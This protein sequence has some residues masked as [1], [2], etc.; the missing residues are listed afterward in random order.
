[1]FEGA[2]HWGDPSLD[3]PWEVA[4]DQ[5]NK[6]NLSIHST[7][8]R[9]CSLGVLSRAE[10]LVHCMGLPALVSSSQIVCSGTFFGRSGKLGCNFLPPGGGI[11]SSY[12]PSLQVWHFHAC[13]EHDQ[14][15]SSHILY[16]YILHNTMYYILIYLY[17][18]RFI[19][20]TDTIVYYDMLHYY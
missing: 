3:G 7:T 18:L 2:L 15:R 20:C 8:R 12:T 13:R 4:R 1:M 17:T 10:E 16:I 11:L 9:D 14:R 5:A 19:P 6:E